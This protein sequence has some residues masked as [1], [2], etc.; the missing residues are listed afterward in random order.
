MTSALQAK[1]PERRSTTYRLNCSAV[2][3][4]CKKAKSFAVAGGICDDMDNVDARRD[5][6]VCDDMDIVDARGDAYCG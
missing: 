6:C 3:A 5:G 1:M 2:G 4:Q